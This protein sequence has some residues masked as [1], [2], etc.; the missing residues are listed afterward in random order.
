MTDGIVFNIQKFSIHD[1][2]GIRTTVFLKGCPLRCLWCHNPEGLSPDPEI[3][4]DASKCIGCRA[5]A[6][7]CRS[8]CHSFS[9]SE[10]T[11][12]HLYERTKCERCGICQENCIASALK[13]VGSRM[14]VGEVMRIVMADKIF[15]ETSG[16]GMTVSGGEPFMQADFTLALLAA[17]KSNG[18]HTAVETCGFC[19]RSALEKA[20]PLT[21]L[22]LFDYKATG[23]D[24]HKKLTGAE[25]QKILSNLF[26]ISENGGR[27]ILRCPIIP[28]ANDTEEH[29]EK[30]AALSSEL[31][32]A[33]RIDLEPYHALGTGKAPKIGKEQP[34]LTEVPSKERMQQIQEFIA[35]RTAV[36]VQIS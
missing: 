7:L 14:T 15:Y 5:C 35:D 17:A 21:D 26:F 34:F 10:N 13:T 11:V 29:F 27:I 25:Q 8:G 28:G 23:N 20:L 36:P 16:G 19:S 4:F 1:G 9:E 3:E 24:L 12:R 33:E 30:I 22:F 2:P 6:S 31:S 18:L 32:G